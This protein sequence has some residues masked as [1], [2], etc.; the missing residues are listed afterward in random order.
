MEIYDGVDAGTSKV[1]KYCGTNGP[2]TIIS[3]G[4]HLFMTFLSDHVIPKNGFE[5]KVTTI[6]SKTLN[7]IFHVNV[8]LTIL[9]I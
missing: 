8:C 5:T 9:Y 2:G 6:K 4:P 7:V 3:S 1:G